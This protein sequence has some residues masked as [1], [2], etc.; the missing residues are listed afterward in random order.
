MCAKRKSESFGHQRLY[1]DTR[2]DPGN[3]ILEQIELTV[4]L[5]TLYYDNVELYKQPYC[6]HFQNTEQFFLS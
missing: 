3:E 2:N 1:D 5:I 6:P 4:A